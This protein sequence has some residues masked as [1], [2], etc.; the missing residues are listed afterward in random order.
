M[1]TPKQKLKPSWEVHNRIL[2]DPKLNALAFYIGYED[3]MIKDALGEKLLIDWAS[4]DIPWNRVQ[5]IRCANTIV[6][7]RAKRIDLFEDNELPAE[8]FR[9]DN[10]HLQAS[11]L[12]DNIPIVPQ[13]TYVATLQDRTSIFTIENCFVESLKLVSYN[14]LTDKY[15]SISA[16]REARHTAIVQYLQ[17]Q[18]ADIILL[19]EVDAPM[20]EKLLKA[21]WKQP[22]YTSDIK[23]KA[24]TYYQELV[25]LSKYPF[26]WVEF[27]YTTNKKFPIASWK[28]NGQPFH[29]ANVHLSSNRTNNATTVRQ[30]QLRILLQYLNRLEGTILIG[31][32][33]NSRG[34]EGLELLDKEQFWDAW[35][36]QHPHKDGYTFEPSY[37]PLAAI[38]TL[39][40]LP[41]RFDRFYIRTSQEQY[42][43]IEQAALFANQM[44]AM[45]SPMSLPS[46]HYGLSLNII[47]QKAT[48]KIEPPSNFWNTIAS[49]YRSAIVIL[50]DE[51]TSKKVQ[52]IRQQFD[53]KYNRWMPH[54]TLLYGFLPDRYFEQAAQEL[55]TVLK[56]FS[57]FEL[58]LKQYQ[59]FNQKTETIAWLEPIETNQDSRLK[60]LQRLM[61]RLF[62]MQNGLPKTKLSFT[63]HL[64]VGQFRSIELAKESLPPWKKTN[65]KVKRLALISR[66]HQEAFKIRYTIDLETGIINNNA[67]SKVDEQNLVELLSNKKAVISFPEQQ[68]RSII[69]DIIQTTCDNILGQEYKLHQ[70]GSTALGTN[71]N[72]SDLDILAVI[73]NEL[74][75]L[76]FLERVQT[77]LKGWY[78]T[79]RLIQDAQVP[80]LKLKMEGISID[81]LCVAYPTAFISLDNLSEKHRYY[82]SAQ[83]W[84]AVTGILEANSILTYSQRKISLDSFRWFV[85]AIKIW[86][87]AR[88]IKGNA[89]GF[90]GTYSWTILALWVLDRIPKQEDLEDISTLMPYFFSLLSQ[91]N[92]AQPITLIKEPRYH[93]REKQDRMPI[94]T[95]I[96]P[97]YNSARNVTRSTASILQQELN[98]GNEILKNQK[99]GAISWKSLF[100]AIDTSS[101]INLT[102]NIKAKSLEQLN[103]ACGWVEG[104]LVGLIIA[105]EQVS[106]LIIRPYPSIEH[107][108]NKAI[109]QLGL[110]YPDRDSLKALLQPY[111]KD[112]IASFDF[113][114]KEQQLKFSF[115]F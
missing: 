56:A 27:Q 85:K 2:W 42:W 19:Q 77:Q 80:I 44:T 28:F 91:Y 110:L 14:L 43:K 12:I 51:H 92:W 50:P 71:T 38:S 72:T 115:S 70:L 29:V 55:S 112:F 66:C 20:L 9:T 37:N 52:T 32:D 94:L 62:V 48:E 81:L 8:A 75:P 4:N 97:Y 10:Q 11:I 59:F 96:K 7:D 13:P 113:D 107:K 78:E 1:K 79:A 87:T 101:T 106:N 15:H 100:M 53:R 108:H 18:D 47:H 103:Q 46:D 31:G 54:I 40:G 104:H 82:F 105:L 25:V 99:K 61:Q 36:T 109:L 114:N 90:L 22:I 16:N 45:S 34:Q 58:E 60:K 89:F 86:A 6:W 63:P 21:N 39:T 88:K 26:S 24:A 73:P 84:Q 5:Y 17:E 98:R 64:S 65:F 23:R 35:S 111:L 57:V 33:F 41:A 93:L 74:D 83:D 69:L 3:R 95:T 76:A 102:I 68:N 67:P 30:E 49:T